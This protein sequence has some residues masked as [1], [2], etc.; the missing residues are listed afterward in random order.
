MYGDNH[1]KFLSP[2]MK[3]MVPRE[4]GHGGTLPTSRPHSTRKA[5]SR[6]VGPPCALPKTLMENRRKVPKA[7]P[8]KAWVLV[9]LSAHSLGH[10]SGLQVSRPFRAD[11]DPLSFVPRAE[12][13]V[14]MGSLS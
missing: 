3:E 4:K 8:G 14:Q 12:G 9:P 13:T 10:L 5:S 11:N 7:L 2:K 1:S 6:E